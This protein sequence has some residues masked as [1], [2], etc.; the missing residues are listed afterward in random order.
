M[1]IEEH[2]G[3]AIESEKC[4]VV[5]NFATTWYFLHFASVIFL[6]SPLI[7]MIEVTGSLNNWFRHNSVCFIRKKASIVGSQ[8]L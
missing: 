1:N 2:I 5:Q 6:L 4:K 8:K 3:F 7:T